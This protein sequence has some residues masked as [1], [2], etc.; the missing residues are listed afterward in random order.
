MNTEPLFVPEQ[1]YHRKRDIHARFGGQEQG[2]M[3]TPAK[4]N[5]IFLVTGNSGRQH[6]YE[7][8]WSE[9]GGTLFYYGE[10]QLGDMRFIKA[11]AALRDHS[12]N[13][14]D[15]HLFEEVPSKSGY[16]RYKGQMICTGYEWVDAPDTERQMR[17]AIRFELTPLDAFDIPQNGSSGIGDSEQD[18][19][20]ESLSELRHKAL[21]DSAETRTRRTQD[22]LPGAKSCSSNVC[23]ATCRR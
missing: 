8:C 10:G 1:L 11:N 20:S 14:E 12:L 3:I 23:S 15:V 17:R 9:D 16:L 5:L 2:G 13:G 22:A 21:A 18:M 19:N 6:G 4:H 7:D